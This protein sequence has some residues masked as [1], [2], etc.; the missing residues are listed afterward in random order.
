MEKS[1]NAV[2]QTAEQFAHMV[3]TAPAMPP[4]QS[5][6]A[7]LESALGNIA[8]LADRFSV[9]GVYFNESKENAA[10]LAAAFALLK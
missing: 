7:A 1:Q 5:R 6:I 4:Q 3:A 2:Q 9:S 10:A 8:D